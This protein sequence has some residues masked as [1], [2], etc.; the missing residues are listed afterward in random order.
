[1]MNRN[2]YLIG[3]MGTGKTCIGKIAAKMSHR[4]FADTDAMIEEKAGKS[5]SEI[6]HIEGEEGFRRRET[7]AL[8]EISSRRGYIVSTGGGIVERPSNIRLMRRSGTVIWLLRDL[9]TVAANPRIKKRPLLAG[10]ETAI[11]R[12]M[13]KR[14]PMYRRACHYVVKNEG[15]RGETARKILGIMRHL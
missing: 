11:F 12:L 1:M 4:R 5:V 15:D 3:M 13:E 14:K 2:I 10:D 6:F 8:R 7:A 9:E